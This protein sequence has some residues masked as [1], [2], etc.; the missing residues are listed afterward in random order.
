MSCACAEFSRQIT[1]GRREMLP[2]LFRDVFL[3]SRFSSQFFLLFH[4]VRL[5]L[6]LGS[7][8]GGPRGYFPP[9]FGSKPS[10]FPLSVPGDI[11]GGGSVIPQPLMPPQLW[12]WGDPPHCGWALG[13]PWGWMLPW[14]LTGCE[15]GCYSLVQGVELG[16][17]GCV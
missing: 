3:S 1:P 12:G 9:S 4:R 8:S 10:T 13:H 6:Y 2:E 17:R 14:P 16:G 11:S 5:C 7:D 15:E